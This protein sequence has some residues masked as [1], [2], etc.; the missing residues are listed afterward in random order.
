MKIRLAFVANSS[1]SSYLIQIPDGEDAYLEKDYFGK[2][3]NLSDRYA[4]DIDDIPYLSR[5]R[6]KNYDE[7]LSYFKIWVKREC[8]M[9]SIRYS[10]EIGIR[11]I[12]EIASIY[13]D[14][15]K[16]IEKELIEYTRKFLDFP[17]FREYVLH[18]LEERSEINQKLLTLNTSNKDEF[19][20]KTYYKGDM[21]ITD[22]IKNS[23]YIIKVVLLSLF[24]SYLT[25][26]VFEVLDIPYSGE[27]NDEID[28]FVES[29]FEDGFGA[30]NCILLDS[31]C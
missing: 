1:S 3:V 6:P 7:I 16:G 2:P 10:D 15:L 31:F 22:D 26:E 20:E 19:T 23:L 8:Q 27:C 14:W 21:C 28:E 5:T 12:E 24:F 4:Y 11:T 9:L 17:E 18:T 30:E 29:E 13:L 25:G